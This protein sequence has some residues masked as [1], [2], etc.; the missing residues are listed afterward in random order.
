[1]GALD[2]Y[3][4][5]TLGIVQP[6]EAEFLSHKGLQ[7][8]R[9]V[10]SMLQ[11]N[12]RACSPTRG[13]YYLD[14]VEDI[15]CRNLEHHANEGAQGFLTFFCQKTGHLLTCP[16]T[17]NKEHNEDAYKKIQ[18]AWELKFSPQNIVRTVTKKLTMLKKIEVP[19][20]LFHAHTKVSYMRVFLANLPSSL[21]E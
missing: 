7:L 18:V 2:A 4:H 16:A 11:C 12:T 9:P 10:C 14:I 5:C 19:R 1:M 15:L 8:F 3:T 6:F 21:L 17:K 20:I 13:V